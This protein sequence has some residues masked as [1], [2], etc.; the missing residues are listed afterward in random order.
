MILRF[1][2]SI[3]KINNFRGDVSDV[4]A[5]TATL[6]NSFKRC[7]TSAIHKS[8]IHS[9][10]PFWRTLD[11]YLPDSMSDIGAVNTI[12]CTQHIMYEYL[13]DAASKAFLAKISA[14]SSR[15]L[16]ICII[17]KMYLLDQR[18]QEPQQLFIFTVKKIS[19]V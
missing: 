17:K 8:Y 10:S 6:P 1:Y 4:S 15:K 18:I 19:I 7:T 13:R 14:R 12:N 9:S 5:V 2:F 3:I 16:F 11:S